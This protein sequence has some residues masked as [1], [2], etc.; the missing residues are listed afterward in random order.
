MS[1]QMFTMNS[2]VVG[3]PCVVTDDLVEVLTKKSVKDGASRFQNFHVNF[4]KFQAL[5][6]TRFIVRLD[7]HKLCA[8]CVPKMLTGVHKT[9]RMALALTF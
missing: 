4:H 7:Y 5:F 3:Q 9:Q 2:K 6:S 1:E 8:R